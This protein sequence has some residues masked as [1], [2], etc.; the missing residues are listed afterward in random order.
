[1]KLQMQAI[2]QNPTKTRNIRKETAK[3]NQLS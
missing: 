2:V 3:L 1:M